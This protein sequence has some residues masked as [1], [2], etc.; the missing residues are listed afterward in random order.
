[1][2]ALRLTRSSSSV[3]PKLVAATLPIPLPKP[4]HALVRIQYA[5]IQPSDRMNAQGHFPSTTFP[6]VPGRD[7]SGIVVDTADDTTEAKSWIGKCVY[8]TS[9]PSLGFDS[10][11]THAQYCLVPLNALVEKPASL[12]LRQAATVGVP[13]TTASLCMRRAQVKPD[14]IVLVLGANGAVGSAVTQMAKAIGCKKVLTAARREDS[15]P[16]ILLASDISGEALEESIST[17]TQNKGVDV[18]IDTVG[19]LAL[20]SALVECLGMFGRYAWIAAPRGD[21]DKRLQ[22]DIFQAYRKGLSLLGCNSVACP[23]ETTA[24]YLRSLHVWIEGGNLKA[25]SE[26]DFETAALDN[27]PEFGYGKTGKVVIDIS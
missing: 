10:D 16:D 1:M 7:Y 25:R 20:M 27:A 13:F 4:G 9:G 18:I 2:K 23:V 12:S 17:L 21:V 22:F 5:A 8:G 15:V 14:D 24:E 11:G 19:D 6:R 3:S 26:G